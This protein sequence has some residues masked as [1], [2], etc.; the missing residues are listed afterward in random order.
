ME[1]SIAV[2]HAEIV[3]ARG[4]RA[5]RPRSRLRR[6][7]RVV[8]ARVGLLAA[9][10][11]VFGLLAMSSL[12][13]RCVADADQTIGATDSVAI[14]SIGTCPVPA[15]AAEGAQNGQDPA[16]GADL[17]LA[18]G[19]GAALVVL[20]LRLARSR[21]PRIP[22]AMPTLDATAPARAARAVRDRAPRLEVLCIL[23]R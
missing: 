15:P 23:R 8:A 13:L 1:S 2:H 20:A 4:R 19:L 9:I 22:Y 17:A 5:R 21:G 16:V 11:I 10:A 14:A 12:G 3:G 6:G 18:A 7:P